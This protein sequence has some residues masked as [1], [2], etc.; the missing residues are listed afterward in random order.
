M[1]FKILDVDD[2][3]SG[4][5]TLGYSLINRTSLAGFDGESTLQLHMKIKIE[6]RESLNTMKTL[7]ARELEVL[8][9]EEMIERHTKDMCHSMAEFLYK[10]LDISGIYKKHIKGIKAMKGNE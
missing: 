5:M 3:E 8:T 6:G 10:E 1:A 2:Y 7:D 4:E 9:I